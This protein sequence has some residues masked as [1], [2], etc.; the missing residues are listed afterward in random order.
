MMAYQFRFQKLLDIKENEKQKSMAE[1]QQSVNEFEKVAKKLYECLKKKEDLEEVKKKKLNNG[2]PVQ[3]MRHYQQ[4]ITNLEKT[5]N[6]YQ[7][8][9]MLTRNHMNE[10]Q[11]LLLEKNKEV[12]QY[13][14]MKQEDYQQFIRNEKKSETSELDQVSLIQYAYRRN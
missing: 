8:L 7:K 6:H 14:K 12:K 10:K 9:V 4:F 5:I 11:L 1:Y 13:E 2:L 3:E